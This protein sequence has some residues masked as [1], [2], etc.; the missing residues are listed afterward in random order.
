MLLLDE[1]TANLDEGTRESIF[2]LLGRLREE[3]TAVVFTTHR[4][5]EV[6]AFADRVITLADGRVV[7]D[8]DANRFARGVSD[9][10]ENMLIRVAEGELERAR[11]LLTSAGMEVALRAG[12][13][14]VYRCQ[15]DQPLRL[16]FEQR[17]DVLE[18]AVGS[19]R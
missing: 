5:D 9:G 17:I 11:K 14:T 15:P 2:A 16:L 18:S 19:R 4:A 8:E 7:D 3:G 12:W 13:L 6:I 10:Q 1:P